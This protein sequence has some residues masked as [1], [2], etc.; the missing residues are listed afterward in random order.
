LVGG[1]DDIKNGIIRAVGDPS[2][3]FIED[4]LRIC[5]VFR[6]AARGDGKIDSTTSM[7]IK[8]DNRLRGIGPKDDVS[9]ERIWEEFKKAWS[10][11]ANYGRFNRYLDLL[12]E[13]DMWPQVFPGSNINT[14][15]VDSKDFV[16]VVAN[17]FSKEDVIGL[18][19]R[20]V[21]GY[22][23]ESDIASKVCFLIDLLDFDPVD[24]FDIYKRKVQVDLSNDTILE[25]IRVQSISNDLRNYLFKFID[26]KPSVLSKDLMDM[27]FKG[28][29]LGVEIK[30]LEY[31]KFME[32]L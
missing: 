22:K 19:S 5:R 26:Y 1:I 20:L 2:K 18:Q 7:A 17:L 24:V 11:C 32:G 3:R 14:K 25:W 27:G 23:I 10:Q 8:K 12:N 30:R 6:F 16:V 13:F 29:E 31:Q 15:F 4:R 21:H 28:K 9:Q